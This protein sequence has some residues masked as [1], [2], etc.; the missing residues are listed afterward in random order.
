MRKQK[1]RKLFFY[2]NITI[3]NRII[4]DQVFS[5]WNRSAN[6]SRTS[7]NRLKSPAR[8]AIKCYEYIFKEKPLSYPMLID[9]M[10]LM[11]V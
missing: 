6:V 4:S 2:I 7:L 10:D 11:N 1:Q 5:C 8:T 9:N 3:A